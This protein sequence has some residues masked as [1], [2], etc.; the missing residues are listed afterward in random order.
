MTDEQRE[1]A[2]KNMLDDI[3]G[4]KNKQV[5]IVR[6]GNIIKLFWLNETENDKDNGT[7]K[8]KDGNN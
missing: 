5:L 6:Q 2:I 7:E 3:V 4:G 8:K 1:K